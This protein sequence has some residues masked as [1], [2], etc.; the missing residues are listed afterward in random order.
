M[1]V[2]KMKDNS[3]RSNMN[4]FKKLVSISLLLV[5]I[6]LFSLGVVA[7][8]QFTNAMQKST[9]SDMSNTAQ[10]KLDMLKKT[11]KDEQNTAYASACNNDAISVLSAMANGSANNDEMNSKKKLVEDYIKDLSEKNSGAYENILIIDAS[12][13][14]IIDATGGKAVGNDLS[15]SKP[16]IEAKKSG[17]TY[18]GDIF[19]SPT[20]G[21]P[22]IVIEVPL[23]DA[24]KVYIGMYCAALEFN[25]LTE[26]LISKA[27]DVSYNYGVLNDQ[28][29]VI[30]NDN[31]DYILKLD[32]AKNNETTKKAFEVMQK[33]VKGTVFL[34]LDG[35][36]EVLSYYKYEDLNLYVY[37][38]QTVD[39]YMKPINDMKKI[40]AAVLVVFIILSAGITFL[41]S[42]SIANPL[43]SLNQA[44]K[45][46]ASGNMKQQVIIPKSKDEIGQLALS[47]S[48]M[49]DNL[50]V[51]VTQVR[52]MGEQV[53][54]ATHEMTSSSEEVG[55]VS[56]Q[57]AQAVN[58]L[59]K[60]ASE[61]A[62]STEKANFKIVEVI[63]GLEDITIE[64]EKSD[65]LAYKANEVV[66][67]GRESVKL[68]GVKMSE[69]L[70]VTGNVGEAIGDLF[71]KATKIGSILEAIRNISSQTN[72][73]ALNAAIEAARV[74]E[75][76]RG[77]AV[78]ADE[79]RKLAEESNQSVKEID[80]IVREVQDG[81]NQA[82]Q[83][84][85]K[86][87]IVV[88]EQ[89]QALS[90]TVDAF[91]S[92]LNAVTEINTNVKSVAVKSSELNTQAKQAG[93][94][95][96]SIAS[97]SEET[98][99]STE[100]VAAST[101]EQ[102]SVINQI[103]ESAMNLSELAEGLQKNINRFSI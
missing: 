42:R 87:K 94:E 77:F 28:G 30:A 1:G 37:A 7:V 8:T 66:E 61:Q 79:I 70:Q 64:M 41:F 26:E 15:Q 102:T 45:A 84:M 19:A 88:G 18:V 54:S 86:V 48:S 9:F 39:S 73:L 51:L 99:S 55:N 21:R 50:K 22:V 4:I 40:L 52:T 33:D 5:I 85:D 56:E 69:N 46:I 93:D 95:M 29:L 91:E 58:D 67:K 98:A 34:T 75:H 89:E 31:K 49:Q 12:G 96:S 44:A 92:I 103:A 81:V 11:I 71:M 57:I 100:E 20:T 6:P 14:V 97:I 82:V 68:Q 24:N 76:G 43:N 59:A 23:Y 72:L 10:I 78:V 17:K 27:P 13:K 101:Q 47:F 62:A 38:V 35:V 16:Y 83:E 80:E 74:G 60:G 25:K 2:A 63:K 32:L 53:T 3:N 65:A 90:E 36:Q